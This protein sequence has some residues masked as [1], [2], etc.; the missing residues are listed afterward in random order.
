MFS[1]IIIFLV[2]FPIWYFYFQWVIR[3]FLSQYGAE[4]EKD[5]EE[6]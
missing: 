6:N 3:D 2:A 1:K 5:G 4:A